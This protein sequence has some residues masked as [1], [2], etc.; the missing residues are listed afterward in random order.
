[1]KKFISFFYLLVSIL[2]FG[3]S[4]DAIKQ[5]DDKIA[6]YSKAKFEN[7][8]KELTEVYY[9]AKDIDYKKGQINA[10]L[11]LCNYYINK[12]ES[13]DEIIEKGRKAEK[14]ADYTDD[15]VSLSVVKSYIGTAFAELG[16]LEESRKNL[17]K[18]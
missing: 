16:L 8:E 7:K 15:Y 13:Y 10:L 6:V 5:I 9:Q 2:L 3:Q 18:V 14:I 12:K 17:S 4:K 11:L 1:M